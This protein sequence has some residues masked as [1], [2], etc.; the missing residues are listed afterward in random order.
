[1]HPRWSAVAAAV[2][3]GVHMVKPGHSIISPDGRWRVTLSIVNAH[4]PK[5]SAANTKVPSRFMGR[6]PP[7]MSSC[8]VKAIETVTQNQRVGQHIL[9]SADEN[10]QT[11]SRSATRGR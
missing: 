6:Y 11:R 8:K 7:R 10:G 2:W 3:P 1:M 5:N 4:P 9:V